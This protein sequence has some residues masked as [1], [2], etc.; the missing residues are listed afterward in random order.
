MESKQKKQCHA[1]IHTASAAAAAVGAGFAQLPGS[2]NTFLTP[3]Q[4]TMT[5]SLGKVFD[6]ELTETAAKAAIA[7]AAATTI[8]RTISQVVVGWLPGVGNV[9]NASTASALTESMGWMLA[10]NFY[11]QSQ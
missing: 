9:I 6:I 4:L 1:I 10:D 2:D 11:K 8:G 5:I 3:I 7:S